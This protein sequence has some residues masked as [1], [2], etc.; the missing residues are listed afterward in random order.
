MEILH[1]R[2]RDV[3]AER[4]IEGQVNKREESEG[5][6]EWPEQ[7][8][9]NGNRFEWVPKVSKVSQ[10]PMAEAGIKYREF[11]SSMRHSTMQVDD[12]F[13][14]AFIK[15]THDSRTTCVQCR[16]WRRLGRIKTIS[17]SY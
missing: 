7:T 12:A 9:E 16:P 6:R 13:G 1:W 10:I 8:E 5:I 3:F 15:V 11:E 17:N 4:K 2:Q 14:E